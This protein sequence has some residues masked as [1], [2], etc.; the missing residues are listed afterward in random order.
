MQH[1]PPAPGRGAGLPLHVL[2]IGCGPGDVAASLAAQGHHVVAI[3]SSPVMLQLAAS[4]AARRPTPPAWE[5]RQMDVQ[6]LREHFAPASFD[7]VLAH[8]VLDYL[9]LPDEGLD[10]ALSV[11]RVGGLLSVVRVN[12][13]SQV[14]RAAL[15]QHNFVKAHEALEDRSVCSDTFRMAGKTATLDEL[16]DTLER[17]GMDLLG[18]YGIRVFADHL[19]AGQLGDYDA[20]LRL[21]RAVCNRQPY[22]GM[23]RYLHSVARKSNRC[24]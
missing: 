7:L 14:L 2:D 1:L 3:D 5:L 13:V 10:Q 23:G 18:T 4:R 21:E 15:R 8:T 20:L 11:L 12:A 19:P 6:E 24:K 17:R 9:P 16:V 22:N